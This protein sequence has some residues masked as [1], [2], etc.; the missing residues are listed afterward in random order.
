MSSSIYSSNLD[1]INAIYSEQKS[2]PV[3]EIT[4]IT[5]NPE[6]TLAIKRILEEKVTIFRIYCSELFFLIE[7]SF[8]RYKSKNKI[9]I[10]GFLPP[11]PKVFIGK[12]SPNVKDF[13]VFSNN[14]FFLYNKEIFV[15]SLNKNFEFLYKIKTESALDYFFTDDDSLFVASEKQIYN[16]KERFIMQQL[17]S[18]EKIIKTVPMLEYNNLVT[19]QFKYI[20]EIHETTEEKLCISVN[21][22]EE[23][24]EI[25]H[26]NSEI[27][28]IYSK[29]NSNINICIF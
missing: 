17:A 22:G 5:P 12:V 1:T 28:M 9:L 19:L 16:V 14:C 23:I 29:K 6:K 24:S 25:C 18:S 13:F 10:E 3:S 8:F 4:I 27:M 21:F 2:I 11:E 26:L 15:Y 20:A 7:N